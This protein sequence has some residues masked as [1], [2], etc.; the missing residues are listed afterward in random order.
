MPYLQ[1]PTGRIYYQ[2]RGH[3][4]PTMLYVHGFGCGG[5]DWLPQARR[6]ER[7]HQVVTFDLRGHAKSKVGVPPW[8]IASF[9][10]DANALRRE[11]GLKNV[12][13][14]GHSMGC[15]I[16][17]EAYR[18]RPASVAGVILVDGSWNALGPTRTFHDSVES[19]GG[20]QQMERRTFDGMFFAGHDPA[21]R[22]ALLP[23]ALAVPENL[24]LAVL[25]STH[26]WDA[27][28]MEETLVSL[29]VPLLVIQSTYIKLPMG[30]QPFGKKLDSPYLQMI[31]H[32]V[33]TA[34]I[35][36]LVGHGHLVMLEAPEKVNAIVGAFMTRVR[37]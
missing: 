31:R 2:S 36:V 12:V 27:Q 29:R 30:R 10:R 35:E 16:A 14:V 23:R 33:P 6:L 7:E 11:L 3:G 25:P 21:L 34:Q 20:Y 13:L 22:A 24:A 4:Q 28:R 1:R 26:A 9:A 15:R 32:W 5:E 19:A 37:S 8:T 17:L 18:Q